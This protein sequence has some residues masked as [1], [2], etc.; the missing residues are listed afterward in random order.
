[1]DLQTLFASGLLVAAGGLVGYVLRDLP[2][3]LYE[4]IRRK[5][6]YNVTVYQ[7]D[8]LFDILEHWLFENYRNR[9]NDVEATLYFD[10]RNMAPGQIPEKELRF[11]QEENFFIANIDGK[12]I[13]ISKTKE[14]L[15]K[16]QS[17]REFYYRRYILKGFQ[18]KDQINGFLQQIVK[19]YNINRKKG[20]LRVYTNDSWGN[21]CLV[22]DAPVKQ[23]SKVILPNQL[24]KSLIDDLEGFAS[25]AEWYRERSIRYKRGYLFYG[26]PGNGKTTIA[27]SIADYL[28]RDI[29]IINLNAFENDGYLIAAFT[30]LQKNVVLLIEDIDRS[31]SGRDNIGSKISFSGMLNSLDG[32][33][34][35]DGIVTVITTNHIEKLDEALIRD[36]RMDLKIELLNPSESEIKDYMEAFYGVKISIPIAAGDHSM[37]Y[38][39]EYCIR[40]KDNSLAAINHFAR[41]KTA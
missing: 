25:S 22:H 4:F 8:E 12:R 1:M 30:K 5:T 20:L 38:I 7:Q 13:F 35:K 33:L 16:A 18:A 21:W 14:K 26:P 31:F 39:Q 10:E 9:Y 15:D 29:Y 2:K 17:L 27:T 34:C 24:K 36:G 3:K 32:V 28:N 41:Q 11:K 23:F 6:M 40:N 37:S 19:E